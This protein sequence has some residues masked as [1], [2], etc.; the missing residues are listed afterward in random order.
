MRAIIVDD[1]S[2]GRRTLEKL[3]IRFAPDVEIVASAESVDT[4]LLAIKE[5]HPQLLFLDIEMPFES[6]FDLLELL[7]DPRPEVIFT[8]A[9]DQYA[10]RAVKS[11]ALDYLLKPIS[12]DELAAAI[13]KARRRIGNA[14]RADDDRTDH[15]HDGDDTPEERSSGQPFRKASPERRRVVIPSDDGLIVV[16]ADDIIRCTADGCYTRLHLLDGGEI[17]VSRTLKEFEDLLPETF[18]VRIHHSHL[19]NLQHMKKYL[20]SDGGKVLMC[21]NTIVLVSRRKKDELMRR[22]LRM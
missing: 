1:E 12:G 20:R 7:P 3:L 16:R 11:G 5:H 4:A 9:Y 14:P 2:R 6:G 22:L 15:H 19:I 21:D 13:A 18:F 17:L 10:L 8:T